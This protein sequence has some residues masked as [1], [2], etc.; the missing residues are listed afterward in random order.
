MHFSILIM[1]GLYCDESTLDQQ[2]RGAAK[3]QAQ[4]KSQKKSDALKSHGT[5]RRVS[6]LARFTSCTVSH[7]GSLGLKQAHNLKIKKRD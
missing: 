3:A 7:V 6:V 1:S 4:A 2:V 5:D